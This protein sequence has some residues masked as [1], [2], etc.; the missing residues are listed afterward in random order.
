MFLDGPESSGR[1]KQ[2]ALQKQLGWYG[3][4]T[5]GLC[6]SN[7][8][9]DVLGQMWSLIFRSGVEIYKV[10]VFPK[11]M[12]KKMKLSTEVSPGNGRL[13]H[14]C[15]YKKELPQGAGGAHL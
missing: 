10:L 7:Q 2:E 3:D 15:V 13:W 6:F 4:S 5:C 1:T 14:R 9:W 8:L 12:H 11:K